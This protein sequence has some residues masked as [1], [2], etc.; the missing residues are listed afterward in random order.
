MPS[1]WALLS[2]AEKASAHRRKR[3][4]ERGSPC[5]S[6]LSGRRTYVS[7]WFTF[8]LQWTVLTRLMI[9]L[10]HLSWKPSLLVITS[11]KFHSSMSY[12]LLISC[13]TSAKPLL[14]FF[15]VAYNGYGTLIGQQNVVLYYP[16]RQKRG[17][18]W[19]NQLLHMLIGLWT[20]ILLG[21]FT[22]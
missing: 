11:K 8:A 9:S 4:S 18:I 14:P 21:S 5:Q 1:S 12:A 22:F 2:N 3:Y 6:L 10:I 19:E 17:L 16:P 7:V 13:F 15:L 20:F